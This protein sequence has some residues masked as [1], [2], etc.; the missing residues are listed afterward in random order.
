MTDFFNYFLGEH[1]VSF[2]LAG[3]LFSL[4]GVLVSKYHFWQKRKSPDSKFDYSFWLRDNGLSVSMSLLSSFLLVRFVDIFLQWINPRIEKSFG[5]EIPVTEDQVFYYLIA[6]VLL[7][8]WMHVK[9]R[10]D[11]TDEHEK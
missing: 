4:F 7:Q 6:G 5:F 9:Y 11:K 3:I 10:K 2:H 1:A 8:F